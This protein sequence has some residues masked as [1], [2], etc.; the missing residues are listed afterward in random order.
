[1]VSALGEFA[2]YYIGPVAG[3]AGFVLGVLMERYR[4]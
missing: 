4:P 1:M 3:I 2:C